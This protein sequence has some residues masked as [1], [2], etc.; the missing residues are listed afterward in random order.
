MKPVFPLLTLS[1]A[2]SVL[3]SCS[4]IMNQPEEK[5]RVPVPPKGTT[6][7]QLPWNKTQKFESE[8]QLGPLANPRR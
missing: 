3:T 5:T 2:L 1:M 6:A 7:S 4:W 8:A